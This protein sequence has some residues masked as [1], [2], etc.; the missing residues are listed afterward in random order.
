[1]DIVEKIKYFKKVKVLVIGDV[2]IDT[3]KWGK[4]D[5]ISPEA[6][7][8]VFN[9]EKTEYRMGGAANVLLNLEALGA[10]V[11][12]A[13]LIGQDKYGDIFLNSLNKTGQVRDTS[14]L[15]QVAE[16]RT[17]CKTRFIA[18]NQH[19]L[20]VD[21]EDTQ[22]ISLTQEDQL[23]ERIQKICTEQ[24]ID[25]AIFEDYNKGILTATLIKRLLEFFRK[26]NILTTVDPKKKNFFAYQEVDIFRK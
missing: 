20:R 18:Q 12:L 5:R 6:P 11:F 3:Y 4:I 21:E 9:L 16:R 10:Q 17:T 7:V 8:P 26:K 2:I 1:M 19:I 23:F 14:A 25:V 24:K 15:L 22:D 13:T